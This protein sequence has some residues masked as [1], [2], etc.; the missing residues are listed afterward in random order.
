MSWEFKMKMGSEC[1]EEIFTGNY[2]N[3][4]GVEGQN[5]LHCKYPPSVAMDQAMGLEE[6]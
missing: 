5:L 1:N 6:P 4:P 3:I 2:V